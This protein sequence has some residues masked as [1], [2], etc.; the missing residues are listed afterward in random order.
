MAER[1]RVGIGLGNLGGFQD[2]LGEFS[3]QLCQRLADQAPDLLAQHGIELTFHLRKEFIGRFG[4]RVSYLPVSRWQRWRHVQSDKFALWHSLNQLDKTLPPQ[5]TAKRLVTVH[6]LNFYYFKQGYSFWR[7][8]RRSRALLNRSNHLVAISKHVQQDVERHLDW[9]GPLEV[10]Y[11]GA[12]DLSGLR[13]LPIEGIPEEPFLFHLSRM[14]RSKNVEAILSLARRWPE[15]RFLLAG[16]SGRSS[17]LVLSRQRS[18]P[19]PNVDVVLGLSDEQKAWAYASCKGF[20]FPS[21]T[22]GFGLPPLEAMH[23]GKP[24]FLSSLTSLPEVGGSC[25]HYFYDF[26]PDAM[27]TVVEHGL[28]QAIG[29]ADQIKA[30]AAG[31]NWDRCCRQYLDLY[32][33]LITDC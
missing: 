19:L 27:R 4:D 26:D 22:E 1:L 12:R 10:I 21:L 6:D 23:F 30:H 32:L 31:F 28:E 14:T 2:G 24:V 5:G 33:R 17:K 13:Q 25:A 11:N 9:T 20:L 15:M 18:A 29:R 8:L 7:D 3:Q 16:P